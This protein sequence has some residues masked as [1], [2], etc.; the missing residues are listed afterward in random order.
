MGVAPG[1]TD[2]ERRLEQRMWKQG[3]AT[4]RVAGSGTVGHASA[5]VVG[6]RNGRV[7]IFEVKSIG[8]IPVDVSD[9]SEQLEEIYQRT[10]IEPSFALNFKDEETAIF[11]W[12]KHTESHI[13]EKEEYEFLLFNN[14]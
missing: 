12:A 3:F 1:G 14:G 13:K 4:W 2:A 7:E 11:R 8:S 10:G 6:I 9:E 5:D